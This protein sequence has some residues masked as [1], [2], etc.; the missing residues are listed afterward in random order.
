MDFPINLNKIVLGT[1]GI[2]GVWGPVDSHE[3]VATIVRALEAG[4]TRI[5]T[6]PAYGNAEMYI[7]QALKE[8]KGPRPAIH[9]KVG[10]LKCFSPDQAL[11]NYDRQAMLESVEN[12]LSTLAV[13]QLDTLFL[14]DPLHL[15]KDRFQSVI[16][17]LLYLRER[18]YAKKVGLGGNLPD[19]MAPLLDSYPFDALMEFNRLNACCTE[20]MQDHLPYCIRHQ[21]NYYVASPLN[22]GLLGINYGKF[23][24]EKPSWLDKKYV[25]VARQAKCLADANGM[26]L[27]S[28]A[29]RFLF[30]FD[31]PISIVIGAANRQELEATLGDLHA[32]PLPEN[33]VNEIRNCTIR[34]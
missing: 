3:S 8:W 32:G 15:P 13:E 12:S 14:H 20:A 25:E 7:G 30:S 27:S 4:I 22:M 1:S 2:G 9:S 6:A 11:F 10:R 33:L 23:T 31:L 24:F 21:I 5:D 28:M 34:K 18:G 19:W 17:N 29:H 16:D 26:E